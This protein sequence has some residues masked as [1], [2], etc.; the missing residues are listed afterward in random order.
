MVGMGKGKASPTAMR[1][2]L[3]LLCGGTEPERAAART[4]H[5]GLINGSDPVVVVDLQSLLR[6]APHSRAVIICGQLAGV[7]SYSVERL[8][9]QRAPQA[10]LVRADRM[11][12]PTGPAGQRGRHAVLRRLIRTP[13]IPR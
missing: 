3:V 1:S 13:A 6:C 8:I 7:S 4:G 10:T 9:K 12:G 2:D 5:E 11:T